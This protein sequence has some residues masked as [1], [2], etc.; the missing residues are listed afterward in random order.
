MFIAFCLTQSSFKDKKIKRFISSEKGEILLTDLLKFSNWPLSMG[1]FIDCLG[2]WSKWIPVIVKI[3]NSI[4]VN[5]VSDKN[6][7]TGY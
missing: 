4:L 1:G 5:S 2:I 6:D 7:F 3:G